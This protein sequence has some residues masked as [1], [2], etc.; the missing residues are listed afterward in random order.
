MVPSRIIHR[1]TISKKGIARAL[2]Q[3]IENEKVI[4]KTLNPN[5]IKA[6]ECAWECK[7]KVLFKDPINEKLTWYGFERT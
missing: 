5:Q 2:L 7:A 6:S 4:F 1:P 3:T